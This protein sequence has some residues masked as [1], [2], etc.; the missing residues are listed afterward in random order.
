MVER[1]K[2]RATRCI[3]VGILLLS[4]AAAGCG[5]SKKEVK[6]VKERAEY[7]YN[8]AYGY[9]MDSTRPNNV[10]AAMHEI[11]QSLK[12]K[13]NYAK[14]HFLAGVIYLGRGIHVKAIGH[15][16]RAIQLKPNY[17]AA[18]NNLGTAYLASARWSDAIK[19]YQSLI[20]KVMYGTPGHAHNN[21]GWAYYKL[22]K[23]KDAYRHFAAAVNLAPQLC[24][25]YNNLALVLIEEKRF[26]RAE[27]YFG[28]AIKRC[29]KYAE[30][31]FHLGRIAIKKR[32]GAS[33]L[34][35]FKT[36]LKYSGDTP[37]NE[38]CQQSIRA[39]TAG[40]VQ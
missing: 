37:L 19:I 15:F 7:H 40:A 5:P 10:D 4:G 29:P 26:E 34:S 16:K 9:Y 8:L 6:A 23:F 17:Y 21:L 11:L 27:K 13:P 32:D 38:R 30:P 1:L 3:L 31:F 18:M 35:H 33:A 12:A 39:L 24:P 2:H 25:A 14:A 22:G 20:G 36:C 28:R